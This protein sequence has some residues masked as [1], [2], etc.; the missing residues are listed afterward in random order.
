MGVGSKQINALHAQESENMN[1]MDFESLDDDDHNE[2]DEY[3]RLDTPP[4]RAPNE[5]QHFKTSITNESQYENDI[6]KPHDGYNKA[7]LIQTQSTTEYLDSNQQIAVI[8]KQNN[9]N[10]ML[11]LLM[12]DGTGYNDN[13]QKNIKKKKNHHQTFDSDKLLAPLNNHSKLPQLSEYASSDNETNEVQLHLD[14]NTLTSLYGMYGS[15]I[16]N[17]DTK[18][19]KSVFSDFEEAEF[20]LKQDSERQ[21]KIKK[22]RKQKIRVTCNNCYLWR[23]HTNKLEIDNKNLL[24]RK[25]KLESDIDESQNKQQMETRHCEELVEENERL[26]IKINE[27]KSQMAAEKHSATDALIEARKK[28]EEQTQFQQKE[29]QNLMKQKHELEQRCNELVKMNDI[30]DAQIEKIKSELHAVQIKQNRLGVDMKLERVSVNLREKSIKSNLNSINE[31]YLNLLK[32]KQK[33][34]NELMQKHSE[35]EKFINKLSEEAK[36]NKLKISELTQQCEKLSSDLDAYKRNKLEL[37]ANYDKMEEEWRHSLQKLIDA[38]NTI[39]TLEANEKKLKTEV[40]KIGQNELNGIETEESAQMLQLKY[41]ELQSQNDEIGAKVEELQNETIELQTKYEKESK[42]CTKIEKEL[43]EW[44][45]KY[46]ELNGQLSEKQTALNAKEIE[47]QSQNAKNERVI[48]DYNKYKEK[49]KSLYSDLQQSEND[50]IALNEQLNE[51][52]EENESKQ[53]E[54]RQKLNNLSDELIEKKDENQRLVNIKDKSSEQLIEREE[55]LKQSNAENDK[56]MDRNWE[57]NEKLNKCVAKMDEYKNTLD[58]IQ[59]RDEDKKEEFGVIS[60]KLQ[61][62]E[63]ERDTQLKKNVRLNNRIKSLQQE[64]NGLQDSIHHLENIID[65]TYG[66]MTDK[67]RRLAHLRRKNNENELSLNK[68]KNRMKKSN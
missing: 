32:E 15:K 4:P 49:T 62:A 18:S 55:Q 21:E 34:T 9:N 57:L 22:N 29:Y 5:F 42:Q 12:D 24:K 1:S 13:M 53:L 64:N 38:Q 6:V 14:G 40:L 26:K 25:E 23:H 56:L 8:N 20:L 66:D 61:K 37:N 52:M 45:A 48:N 3:Q 11:S 46:K 35:D 59:Q 60:D 67:E 68:I 31:K 7:A 63:T 19:V 50:V 54:L 17:D 39:K 2:E 51:A 44:K 47:L 41:S 65:N 16:D 10:S 33:I 58:S 27:L 28:K 43:I 30:K 36:V